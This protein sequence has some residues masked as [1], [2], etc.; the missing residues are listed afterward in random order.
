MGRATYVNIPLIR[1]L[2]NEFIITMP[3]EWVGEAYPEEKRK[4]GL[5]RLKE[6]MTLLGTFFVGIDKPMDITLDFALRGYE[7]YNKWLVG[8]YQDLNDAIKQVE[9]I[10]PHT[11][12]LV[13]AL[14]FYRTNYNQVVIYHDAHVE[15]MKEDLRS[16]ILNEWKK[17]RD[18]LY[19]LPYRV[20]KKT[21]K[22]GNHVNIS[23]VYAGVDTKP[24]YILVG[25]P[26]DNDE[27]SEVNIDG[28]EFLGYDIHY[29]YILLKPGGKATVDIW[30]GNR[31]RTYEAYTEPV[32]W[33]RR[34]A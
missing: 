31:V 18:V 20:R 2:P 4:K 29:A 25:I 3:G 5:F 24:D 26:Y 30:V 8:S 27:A 16:Y 12:A 6:G 1:E 17:S 19:Y 11:K 32:I 28:G 7:V 14:E 21:S 33:Y 23:G 22:S 15:G 13:R 34:I 9:D 10:I